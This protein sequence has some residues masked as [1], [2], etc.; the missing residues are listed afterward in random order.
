MEEAQELIGLVRAIERIV[1][2]SESHIPF[3]AVLQLPNGNKTYTSVMQKKELCRPTFWL[4]GGM[5]HLSKGQIEEAP[6]RGN[7]YSFEDALQQYHEFES[8]IDIFND[9]ID[10]N[11]DYQEKIDQIENLCI[12]IKDFVEE[13]RWGHAWFISYEFMKDTMDEN[14]IY[15][16]KY[17]STD[18]LFEHHPALNVC[19]YLAKHVKTRDAAGA[20][21]TENINVEDTIE[22]KTLNEYA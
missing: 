7:Q 14:E 18:I 11:L 4:L 13:N 3:I 6:G 8:Q 22:Y 21:V 9:D 10:V 12:Q 19:M 20:Y 15:T 1:H 17:F 5:C 16:R 2:F